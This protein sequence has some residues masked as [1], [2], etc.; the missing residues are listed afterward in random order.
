MRGEQNSHEAL[1]H[2]NFDLSRLLKCI[3]LKAGAEA[4]FGN[5]V[6]AKVAED[7][8]HPNL[9]ASL[10][11][12]GVWAQD[13]RLKVDTETLCTPNFLNR[14]HIL[15]GNRSQRTFKSVPVLRVSGPHRPS[16]MD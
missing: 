6:L 15:K 2:R 11:V 16:K 1:T 3:I 14:C 9:K 10:S 4:F 8:E 5:L 7:N 13:D 12:Y